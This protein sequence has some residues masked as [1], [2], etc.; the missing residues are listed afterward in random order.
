MK[1]LKI[2]LSS[3]IADLGEARERVL[4]YLQVLSSGVISMEIFG[5]DESNPKEFCLNQARQCN[6][7]IGVYAER[8]GTIDKETD[9]SITELE[10]N[11][12]FNM[13]ENG[14]LIGLLIY[15][16]DPQASWPLTFIDRDPTDVRK[17]QAFKQKITMKHTIT[18]FKCT[19][20]L[21]FFILR[22][23]I[24]KIGLGLKQVL[25]PKIKANLV[26]RS[27]LDRPVG[28]EYYSEELSLLFFGRDTEADTLLNQIIK[29]KVSL[30]IGA[31]G[32]GK[33]SLLCAGLF[34]KLHDL[35]WKTAL[36]RPL[37]EPIENL[38]KSL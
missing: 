25:R 26:K 6:L 8:Y 22:D 5:S 4:K 32:I 31:S 21:P 34:P 33:T 10:Y 37:A 7:F 30:L 29:H 17:L 14:Q 35:G 36:I 19:E 1:E 38:C 24:R 28:M 18:F 15:M 13:L 12:A 16:I 11:E 23:I 9:L 3:T 27:N 20:D 2:F